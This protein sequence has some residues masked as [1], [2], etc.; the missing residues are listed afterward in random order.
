[1]NEYESESYMDPNNLPEFQCL[2]EL[3]DCGCFEQSK[4]PHSTKCQRFFKDRQGKQPT[5]SNGKPCPSA[6]LL[7][8]RGAPRGQLS[9]Y[10][11]QY[12]NNKNSTNKISKARPSDSL[13]V[14]SHNGVKSVNEFYSPSSGFEPQIRSRVLDRLSRM[15]PNN[16]KISL[17]SSKENNFFGHDD[18]HK[19]SEH[20]NKSYTTMDHHKS[21]YLKTF[22]ESNKGFVDAY[23]ERKGGDLVSISRNGTDFPTINRQFQSSSS[24]NLFNSNSGNSINTQK[25]EH[26]FRS[27]WIPKKYDGRNMFVSHID[28]TL[29]PDKSGSN[30]DIN[31]HYNH[32]HANS[33][34]K[35]AILTERPPYPKLDKS[36][37]FAVSNNNQYVPTVISLPRKQPLYEENFHEKPKPN[38]VQTSPSYST[39]QGDFIDNPK[40]N[41]SLKFNSS[42]MN[43][44]PLCKAAVL[45][46]LMK[47]DKYMDAQFNKNREHSL[48]SLQKRHGEIDAILMNS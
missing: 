18:P 31:T 34:D 32:F 5:I 12:L 30:I 48:G 44:G 1:M 2:C 43:K 3:C 10:Q 40:S 29:F 15:M 45:Q 33:N 41:S 28:S 4:Q 37:R 25:R 39:Y 16:P 36:V 38:Y 21:D 42:S 8:Q 35:Q 22:A 17:E 11:Y 27:P 26:D 47:K 46:G 7:Q 14:F 23:T 9:E 6:A 24:A 20:K 13:D 19:I